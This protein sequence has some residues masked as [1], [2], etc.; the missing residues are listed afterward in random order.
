MATSLAEAH[1]A[2]GWVRAFTEWKF[3]EGLS[4]LQRAKELSPA[5]PTAND[6]LA[7]VIVYT[8]RMKEAERQAR[9]AVE[10]DPLSAG[11]QFTLGRVLFYAGKLDEADAAGRKIAELQP[12][13]SS[14]HRWQVLVAVQRGDGGT[15]LRGA[16]IEPDGRSP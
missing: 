6:L 11:D 14:R 12:S 5:N 10:L 13:T 8:G 9:Q 3:A 4:E 16:H 7:R 2:L 1:G 15:A